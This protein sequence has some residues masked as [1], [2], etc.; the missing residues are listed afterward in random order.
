[1]QYTGG[2]LYDI[3]LFTNKICDFVN[4]Q[5]KGHLVVTTF[6][7]DDISILFG[8]SLDYLIKGKPALKTGTMAEY[9]FFERMY[10]YYESF[11][12]LMAKEA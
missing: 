5:V 6:Q 4:Q 9:R 12:L 2:L 7:N 8:V 3:E 1:M 11:S 10:R